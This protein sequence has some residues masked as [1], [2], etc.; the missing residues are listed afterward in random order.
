MSS[1]NVNVKETVRLLMVGIGGYAFTYL[2]PLL[3]GVRPDAQIVACVDPYPDSCPRIGEIRERGIPVYA[4]MEAFFAAGGEADLAV[5]TTPIHLHVPQMKCALSHG[6][7]V[8]CEKP[9][10]G[11]IADIPGM[12]EAKNA[13]G[14]YVGIGYQWSHSA[15]IIALKEDIL[16]GVYGKPKAFKTLVLWPRDYAYYSRG[17]GWAGKLRAPDGSLILDSVAN[18]ATAHYLHNM[19][20]VMGDKM[21]TAAIPEKIEAS[22]WRA[23]KIENYDTCS[24]SLTFAGG[25]T[26]LFIVSHASGK[27]KNPTFEYQFERGRVVFEDSP[28]C[29]DILGYLPDGTV[30]NY[31]NP[32]ADV[33]RKLWRAVDAAK[34]LD[35][36]PVCTVET[37]APH[38]YCI[39]EMQKAGVQS[40]P[41]EAVVENEAKSAVY[42]PGLYEELLDAYAKGV[43]WRGLQKK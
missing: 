35:V 21:D 12:I 2:N 13:S 5:L 32:N 31:G 24:A 29:R 9:L 6:C 20:F 7:H 42:V 19:L 33:P 4:D 15:A 41:E 34:G 36:K 28:Q 39:A 37:A 3:D 11:D 26:A 30:K 23:N 43:M 1:A 18:N 27:G 8:L 16:S 38:A 22:L 17:M 14:K 25:A 40:F 10:C